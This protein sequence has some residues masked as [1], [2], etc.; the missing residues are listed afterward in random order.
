[1][2]FWIGIVFLIT[3]FV[4]AVKA[5][6]QIIP[7]QNQ[8]TQSPFGGIV[9]ATSTSGTAKLG[10]IKGM[11]FGDVL[12]WGTGGQW[13]TAATSSL[14]IVG[15]VSSVFGRTGAVTAQVG[16]YSAFYQPLGNYLTALTGDGTASGPGSAAFTLA[17]VNSSVGSFTNANITVNGKGLITAASNGSSS[18]SG[19]ISTSSPLVAGQGVYATSPSTIASAATS[20]P[21]AG[22][23]ITYSG[24]FGS[25]FG[26]TS[27]A[28]GCTAASGAANGCLSSTD[29][30]TFNNKVNGVNL[31]V[32]ANN[33][34]STSSPVLITASTTIGNGTAAG[35]LTV[36]GNA[37]TTGKLS[38]S[39]GSSSDLSYTFNDDKTTGIFRDPSG[40]AGI[41]FVAGANFG[42]K[43]TSAQLQLGGTMG[44]GW[45]SGASLGSGSGLDTLI[46]R[47]AAATFQLGS[48]DAI[49]PVAQT[50]GV[51]SVVA[52]TSDT[53]GS[54]FTINGS[55]GT[56]LGAGG[57][58]IFKTAP[59]GS[60]GSTQNALQTQLTITGAGNVG[61]GTTTPGSL[62]SIGDSGSTNG[63]NFL[64]GTSSFTGSA[65]G[66]NIT[67]GCFSIAGTCVG[68]G[69]TYTATYPILITGSVI[70]TALSSSTLTA[71]SPLTGSFAQVGTGGALGIQAASASQ[72]GYLSLG[73]YS[74]LHTATTTFSSP[75][76]YSLA[77]NAVT[78][79][80]CLTSFTDPNWTFANGA[81]TP[82][83]TVGILVGA[84]STI[85]NGT[86]TG[87]LTIS[88]GATTTGLAYFAGNVGIGTS[89]PVA[90]FAIAGNT[91]TVPFTNVVGTSRLPVAVESTTFTVP[92]ATAYVAHIYNTA[93]NFATN[94]T[95][96]VIGFETSIADAPT[97]TTNSGGVIVGGTF[98]ARHAGLGTTA[99]VQALTSVASNLSPTTVTTMQGVAGTV[100][101]STNPGATTTNAIA[102]QGQV[103]I[104]SPF[105]LVTN[106]YSNRL[107]LNHGNANSNITNYYGSALD[108]FANTGTIANTFGFYVGDI[109]TGTQTNT[110]FSF[111]ASDANAYNYFAGNTGFNVTTPNFAQLE[112]MGTTT[113][114]GGRAFTI[115]D[116]ASTNIFTVDNTGTTT[117]QHGFNITG[118]G[119]F[120]VSGTCLSSGSSLPSGTA[121]QT[122]SYVGT[123]LTATSTITIP[124]SSNVGVASTSPWG[125]LSV[126]GT[127]TASVASTSIY[128]A[129]GTYTW[130]PPSLVS[131]TV[132]LWGGGGGGARE[133]SGSGGGGAGGY[134]TTTISTS[135]ALTIKIGQGGRGGTNAAG[136]NGGTGYAAGANGTFSINGGGGGGGSTAF[137]YNVIA[138][139]GGG[140]GSSGGPGNSASGTSGGAGTAG[141]GG[142]GGGGGCGTAGSGTTGGTG[143][144][145][146]IGTAGTAANGGA[147]SAGFTGN[148]GNAVTSTGGAGS[149]GAA[150]GTSGAGTDGS[151]RDS[152]GGGGAA[153]GTGGAGG[154]PGGGGGDNGGAS[155]GN[156]GDGEV[157]ITYMPTVL[158]ATPN[159][160]VGNAAQTDFAVFNN[161]IVDIGTTSQN[162][163][164]TLQAQTGLPIFSLWNFNATKQ[165]EQIDASG[166]L[167]TGGTAPS[168]GTGCS[169]VTGD[170]RTMR[171]L[172]GSGVT[173]ITVNFASTYTVTPICIA[174]EEN[175]LTAT[176]NA[177][178]TPTTVVL[179]TGT[180]LTSKIIGIICQSSTNF[181]F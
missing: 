20:T 30:T 167:I 134:Y 136:G 60:T 43:I 85:G 179:T 16:D 109:T 147:A 163:A 146:S 2:K 77:S 51:Q 44:F 36:N 59:A 82:T 50:L 75:L 41:G 9:Y 172:T 152:G 120:A 26:G 57:N 139:G 78:C 1:M 160:V 13:I 53:A 181:T 73:D 95:G 46:T 155:A 55:R 180:S 121:G 159:F 49:S 173:S 64:L 5:D 113:T 33:A 129:P 149:G 176:V 15:G 164:F 3:I 90:Q 103:V 29:W 170:D 25:L 153:G 144:S 171:V 101:N 42:S 12:I 157:Y 86:A 96:G 48:T 133:G 135:T 138:C 104:N 168:C 162:A 69:T 23:P 65:H 84:S 58:I 98:T 175:A 7:A 140:G 52:G 115:W 117:S 178:T 47:K 165:V 122:L 126:A 56:G 32:Y 31:W 4:A 111:Y 76:S 156:G 132:Y 39:S 107:L 80:T 22:G 28:F 37:T 100:Q 124:T 19:P 17:T 141:T 88:G 79:P 66:I 105:G 92:S 97:V 68:A 174:N 114:A 108:S 143:G 38:A 166:H 94:N 34:V 70:S 27:G 123:T 128:K 125:I 169:S 91:P 18:G 71:S 45:T 177:S 161:S 150:G 102:V 116:S 21:S 93:L 61:I 158:L 74:L 81:L 10:Q 54:I 62:L 11:A 63:I 89:T 6:A 148:G 14:G 110:P 112:I 131:V 40:S 106:A 35:G 72:N 24:T 154:T 145:A 99:S 118:G 130:T 87:G 119:C 67:S 83:T 8:V 142:N 127:D 137:G 151:G